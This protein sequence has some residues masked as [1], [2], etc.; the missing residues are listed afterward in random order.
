M[1]TVFAFFVSPRFKEEV[2]A[3]Y[4]TSTDCRGYLRSSG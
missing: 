2:K 1:R 3:I 4:E